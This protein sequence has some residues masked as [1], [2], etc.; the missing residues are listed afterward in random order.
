M[1]LILILLTSSLFGCV[2]IDPNMTPDEQAAAR[3]RN[4]AVLLMMMHG[5]D[6]AVNPPKHEDKST[7]CTTRNVMGALQTYCD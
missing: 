6:Q 3:A 2:T 5:A 4:E 1:K 7:T